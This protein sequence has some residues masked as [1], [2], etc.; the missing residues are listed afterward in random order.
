[1]LLESDIIPFNL[2]SPLGNKIIV[3]SPH[4]DDEILGCGGTI[5]LLINSKKNIKVIFLTSG[6]KADS[7]NPASYMRHDEEHITDYSKMREKEAVNSLRVLGISD[8]EFLRFPDRSLDRLYDSVLE[9]L[10]AIIRE[11]K[12]DT[13]YSPSTIELNP[14]H[15]T[16]AKLSLEIQRTMTGHEGYEPVK[17]VFYEVTT[18]LRPNMLIDITSVYTIKRKAI[19]RYKSQLKIRDYLKLITALN[20]LRSLTVDGARYVEAF[21]CADKPLNSED[22]IKWLSYQRAISEHL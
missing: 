2:S 16:T 20:A 4:P 9:R 18:P 19:K 6:D 8:Y 21:W 14:D 7:S 13:I 3:L 22:V 5:R 11:Y 15:R 17:L 10:F 1:M 12:P